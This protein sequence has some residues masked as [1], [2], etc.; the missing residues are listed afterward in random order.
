MNDKDLAKMTVDELWAL[1]EK[2]RAT[3]STRLD[4][5]INALQRRLAQING[6]KDRPGYGTRQRRPY[7]KVRPKYRIR[8]GLLKL[9]L[10]VACNRG[11]YVHSCAQERGSTTS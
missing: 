8:S 5:D 2:V 4:A 7:P 9:G 3:L 10:D 6:H 11:G 1:H